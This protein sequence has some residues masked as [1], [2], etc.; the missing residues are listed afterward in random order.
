M[1]NTLPL[2]ML[3]A[4]I[5]LPSCDKSGDVH[6]TS[7]EGDVMQASFRIESPATRSTVSDLS[8]YIIEAYENR[9]LDA[10]PQRIEGSTGSLTLTLQKN[11]DYTFLFWADYGTARES[12]Y[13]ASD[14]R[15]V[16]VH[17]ANRNLAG[18]R[19]YCFATSFN[20]HDF[21]KNRDVKLGNAVAEVNFIETAGLSTTRNTFRVSYPSSQT[22]NVADGKITDAT[23]EAMTHT[24]TNI[25]SLVSGRI[26]ATDYLLTSRD[27]KTLT[28]IQ[29]QINDEPQ[30]KINNV[31]LQCNFRTNIRGEYSN[32]YALNFTISDQIDDYENNPDLPLDHPATKTIT[33]DG[34]DFEFILVKK[35]TFWMGLPGATDPNMARPYWAQLTQDY[36]IS[37]TEVTQEQYQVVMGNNPS[38]FNG[39]TD[40]SAHPPKTTY[41]GEVQK[42]RPV[43][44]VTWIMLCSGTAGDVTVT[45]EA[46]F[47]YK[48]SQAAALDNGW[49]FR[50]PSEAQWEYAA[51]GGHLRP[52]YMRWPGTDDPTEA[53][54]Y[55]WYSDNTN[56]TGTH[57]VGLK[58]PNALGLYDMVGNV[59]EWCSSSYDWYPNNPDRNNPAIDPD[60]NRADAT[61]RSVRGGDRGRTPETCNIATR[62]AYKPNEVNPYGPYAGIRLVLV[63]PVR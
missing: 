49:E 42:R 2:L 19:A 51:R 27:Q 30:K 52:G 21:D 37:R 6:S 39:D 53:Y 3:F 40:P 8:R 57:E 46:C 59:D 63:P 16:T 35:G 33:I 28:H 34:V 7:P 36:Y 20:S 31:P 47:L 56:K 32:M 25:N 41:P 9:D 22:F 45:P 17:P 26:I 4:M 11:T 29:A 54:D 13:D 44:F 38:Y 48:I 5:V 58:K 43:E 50:L 24:F 23:T 61:Y 18:E 1:K 15:A 62:Y 60:P 10:A 12:Y 14:L 55:C